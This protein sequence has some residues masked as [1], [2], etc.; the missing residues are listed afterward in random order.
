MF[1]VIVAAGY[2][3]FLFPLFSIDLG[4]N[5]ADINNIYVVGQLVV[6]VSI[7]SIERTEGR[8]GVWRVST[9]ALASMG[10]VFLLF[11]LNAT[12]VWSITVV[13]LIGVLGK[14]AESWRVLWLKSASDAGVPAGRATSA[15]FATR[16]LAL[17]AQPFILGA[18]LG[19]T[20]SVAVI[21]IG[22]LC[23]VCAGLFYLATRRSTLPDMQ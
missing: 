23:L 17:I 22:L 1:P 10:V 21:V 5:K 9:V 18:L 8:F 16:S 3:S 20:D 11:A 13:A 7:S 6:Y 2:T 12:L 15:M 14:A 4:L 19:A